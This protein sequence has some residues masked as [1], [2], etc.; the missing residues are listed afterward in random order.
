M[1]GVNQ[2]GSYIYTWKC[3]NEILNKQKCLFFSKIKDKKL[4]QLLSGGWFQWDGEDI[5]KGC[6]R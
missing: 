4:E 6:R 5:R 1:E 2:F 3:H